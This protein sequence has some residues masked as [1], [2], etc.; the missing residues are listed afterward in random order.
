MHGSQGDVSQG[1]ITRLSTFAISPVDA[2]P[3]KTPGTAIRSIAAE[4]YRLTR[5]RRVN[6]GRE[7][8]RPSLI[9][10]VEGET[11][12]L[13]EENEGYISQATG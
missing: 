4:V 9:H 13:L 7:K 6:L 10:L 11:S 5:D 8:G 1:E 3:G 12:A 2:V